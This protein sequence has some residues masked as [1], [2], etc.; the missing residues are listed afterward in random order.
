MCAN[1]KNCIFPL[2]IFLMCEKELSHNQGA[3]VPIPQL[4][5]IPVYRAVCPDRTTKIYQ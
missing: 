2:A 1:G 5:Q 4:H 3:M